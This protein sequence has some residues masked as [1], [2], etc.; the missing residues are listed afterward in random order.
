MRA[1]GLGFALQL[2]FALLVC[3]FLI[4]PIVMSILAGLTD[5]TSPG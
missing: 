5:T 2:A 4:V 3:A 1:R